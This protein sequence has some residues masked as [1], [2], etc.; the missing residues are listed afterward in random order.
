[1]ILFK[2]LLLASFFT[3]AIGVLKGAEGFPHVPIARGSAK[4]ISIE[5]LSL[6]EKPEMQARRLTVMPFGA[7]VKVMDTLLAV[8]DS[9]PP[10]FVWEGYHGEEELNPVPRV[11]FWVK[12]SY[13]GQVGYAF[14][15]YL[16]SQDEIY[17]TESRSILKEHGFNQDFVLLVPG[18]TCLNNMADN[19][20]YTWFGIY[21]FGSQCQVRPVRLR[22]HMRRYATGAAIYRRLVSLA[23]ENKELLYIVGARGS[24]ETQIALV[25][26]FH[27]DATIEAYSHTASRWK[28]SR[29]LGIEYSCDSAMQ[30]DCQG[31]TVY[32][33]GR[34]TQVLDAPDP[35]PD[36]YPTLELAADFDGDGKLD[37]IIYYGETSSCTILYL[38]RYARKG[39]LLRPVAIFLSGY[40]C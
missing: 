22:Q 1:M 14:D 4:V 9:L 13:Q 27:S 6:R 11:G 24:F 30:G 36:Y 19:A 40:C 18:E 17:E 34:Q 12:V 39:E 5:G 26:A 20:K 37:F 2:A 35:Y 16:L 3:G 15:I 33:Q 23:D 38:S 21:Q 28:Q 29:D 31:P 7:A 32:R 10:L 8:E 25:R